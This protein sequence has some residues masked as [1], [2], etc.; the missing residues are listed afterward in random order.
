MKIKVELYCFLLSWHPYLI[1]FLATLRVSDEA[2]ATRILLTTPF[3]QECMNDPSL[4]H[5]SQ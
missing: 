1:L 3:R 4:A 5:L 2:N